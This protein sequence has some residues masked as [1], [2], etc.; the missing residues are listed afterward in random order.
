MKIIATKEQLEAG[1]QT[2][3]RAVSSKNTIPAL[4][5]IYLKTS[6]DNLVLKAT[7]LE[8]GIECVIAAQANKEGEVVIPARYFTEIVKKLPDEQVEI[9]VEDNY[10]VKISS[11]RSLFQIHGFA[12]HDFPNLPQPAERKID[13]VNKDLLKTAIR[14]TIFA[15][16]SSENRPVLTGV[17]YERKEQELVT[18]ATDGHRLAYKNV[19]VANNPN[20]RN[21]VIIP[22]KT[23]QE[24][25]RLLANTEEET[26]GVIIE[27]NQIFFDLGN[28]KIY[29]RLVEGQYPNYEGV[30][31][32][33]STIKVKLMN[34]IFADALE[35]CSLLA[36]DGTNLV[37]INLEG[38]KLKIYSESPEIGQVY[39]E[40]DVE[41]EGGTIE[42]GFNSRYLLEGLRAIEEEEVGLEMNSSLSPATL[43]PIN[44][45]NYLYV[46][47]PVRLV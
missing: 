6:P 20:N 7:D 36:K 45:D 10:L 28:V 13:W 14:Q 33:S 42:I 18:V 21:T 40:I 4:S 41:S 24:L 34:K 39:E 44:S 43:R 3:N 32:K 15:T 22:T 23:L 30:I 19:E 17:L 27:N 11:G 16:A 38:N 5:G 9:L 35:R 47:M 12:P 46:V 2:V 29:S 8:I 31:P 26:V 1:T 25:N 37:R